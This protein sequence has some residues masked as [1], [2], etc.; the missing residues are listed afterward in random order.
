MTIGKT[1]LLVAGFLASVT[2][3]IAIG[4]SLTHRDA[5]AAPAAEA[6]PSAPSPA[7]A[8]HVA[9]PRVKTT[10]SVA[11]RV[12]IPASAVAFL[13]DADERAVLSEHLDPVI[14]SIAHVDEAIV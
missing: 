8:P 12:V 10:K 4:P 1:L 2:L 5:P 6:S 11:K 14:H 13:I 7:S 3:G 9:A